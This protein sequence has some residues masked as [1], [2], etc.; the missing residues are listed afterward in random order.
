MK[1][2]LIILLLLFSSISY[3]QIVTIPDAYFKAKLLEASPSNQ[4]DSLR[5]LKDIS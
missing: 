3:A 2:K 1:V 5:F 4:I